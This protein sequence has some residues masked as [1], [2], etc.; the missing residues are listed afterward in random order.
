MLK[1]SET[2]RPA[3]GQTTTPAETMSS[4]D[5]SARLD[6]LRELRDTAE[7]DRNEART[8]LTGVNRYGTQAQREEW[9]SKLEQAEADYSRYDQEYNELLD[10]YYQTENEEKRTS[11]QQDEAMSGQYQSAQDIQSDM[12]KVTPLWPT[13][14][15]TTGTR[16]RW[17]STSS[18]CSTSTGWTR[19]P[20]ISTPSPARAALTFPDGRRVQQH[21]R[22]VPGAPG[23]EG[24]RGL[25]AVRGRL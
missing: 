23:E 24:E 3:G 4:A 14:S 2:T 25:H 8:V 1:Q 12:D 6:E 15:P 21:L 7:A 10:R 13:P 5:M 16:P 18:I 22:A 17:R 19:R 20:S 9:N 11:L